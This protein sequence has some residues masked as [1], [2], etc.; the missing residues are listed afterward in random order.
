MLGWF[1]AFF[2]M[3]N[4]VFFRVKHANLQQTNDDLN[5]PFDVVL[6]NAKFSAFVSPFFREDLRDVKK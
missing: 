6:L 1:F 2:W 5:L 3:I 4:I